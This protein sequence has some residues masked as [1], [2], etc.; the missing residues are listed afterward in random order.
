MH[1]CT[2]PTVV[3]EWWLGGVVPCLI[4]KAARDL[5]YPDELCWDFNAHGGPGFSIELDELLG[6]G[7]PG[8]RAA[9]CTCAYPDP[10]PRGRFISVPADQCSS[11]DADW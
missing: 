5:R 6:R 7:I 10:C 11:D 9:R 2:H 3:G 4:A 1:A 8:V